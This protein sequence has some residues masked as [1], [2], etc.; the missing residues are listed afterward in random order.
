MFPVKSHSSGVD[1]TV[2]LASQSQTAGHRR[3]SEVY[4]SV[5]VNKC[6]KAPHFAAVKPWNPAKMGRCVK[7]C[8]F[9][10]FFRKGSVYF[11]R[12]LWY[13]HQ[14]WPLGN[15]PFSSMIVPLKTLKTLIYR[16]FPWISRRVWL[17]KRCLTVGKR[18]YSGVNW[19]DNPMNSSIFIHIYILIYRYLQERSGYFR[20]FLFD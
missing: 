15:L 16:E 1:S 18:V 7:M 14:T 4:K 10:F 6:T 11:F 5:C 19:Q 2:F 3:T 13:L 8:F 17:R 9:I 12:V 20:V